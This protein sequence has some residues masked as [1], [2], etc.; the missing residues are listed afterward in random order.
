M[1]D[2]VANDPANTAV[3]H[4]G[5]PVR[6]EEVSLEDP[7]WELDAVLYGGVEGVHHCRG[8]VTLPVSF[9]HLK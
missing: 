9:I 2:L 4:V 3:V 6:P 7:G 1:S 8:P 5:R